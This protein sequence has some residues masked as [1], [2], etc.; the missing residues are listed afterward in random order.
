MDRRF[1]LRD[2]KQRVSINK[3]KSSWAKVPSWVPQGSVLGPVLFLLYINDLPAVISSSCKIFADDTKVYHQILSLLDQDTLQS[4]L[5]NLSLW[6]EEWLL[7][8]NEDKC[9]EL[10]VGKQNQIYNYEMNNHT[11][12]NVIEKKD[13]GILVTDSLSFSKYI[14]KAAS[15]ANS[16]LG[17]IKRTFSYFSKDSL[18]TLYKSYVRPHLEFCVQ[19]WSPFLKKDKVI[20]E[21]I[22]RRATKLIPGIANLSYEEKLRELKLTTLRLGDRG[23]RGDLIKVYKILNGLKSVNLNTFLPEGSIRV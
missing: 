10:H 21:K 11:L 13:L 2:R 15:K 5:V 18:Q 23:T 22:Q 6:S 20:L 3:T 12:E 16:I 14:G 4:D 17:M 7:G 9:K 8:F 19:A 1:F